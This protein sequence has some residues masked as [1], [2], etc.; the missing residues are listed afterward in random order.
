MISKEISEK[1]KSGAT[2]R[3]WEKT[4]E[5]D[6]ERLSKFEGLV[7]A[8]KHGNEPGATFTVRATVAGVGVEKIFPVHSPRISKVDV[9]NSPRKV[10]RSK[11]Y[12]IRNLSKRETRQKIGTGQEQKS[13][14]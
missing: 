2:I 8:R 3:V 1:I 5:G 12:Y 10:S 9:L 14:A 11:L 6:K 13:A 7:L 4:K